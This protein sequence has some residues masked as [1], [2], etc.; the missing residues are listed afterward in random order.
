MNFGNVGEEIVKDPLTNWWIPRLNGAK[1]KSGS[2]CS[3][4]QRSDR[5][6]RAHLRP[7]RFSRR[8]SGRRAMQW[9]YQCPPVSTTLCWIRVMCWTV[10]R[11]RLTSHPA[12]T[13]S[14][15]STTTD[16]TGTDPILG[17]IRIR[18]EYKISLLFRTRSDLIFN[19]SW[20]I[21][22]PAPRRTSWER[23]PIRWSTADL[24]LSFWTETRSRGI[25][26]LQSFRNRKVL[27]GRGIADCIHQREFNLLPARWLHFL[28]SGS[29]HFIKSFL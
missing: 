15:A 4:P 2:R 14:T 22:R 3:R 24:L 7:F 17:A 23:S 28:T 8:Q 12:V 6:Q 29:T 20:W 25:H 9:T 21:L 11:H 10:W 1:F 27:A 16:T 5:L 19:S 18:T 13:G 26:P